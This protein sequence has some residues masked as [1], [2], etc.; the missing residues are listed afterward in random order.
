MTADTKQAPP[1]SLATKV[2][3]ASGGIVGN[4][5][6]R[7]LGS[8][9]LIFYNQVVGLPAALVASALLITTILDAFIDPALGQ[10]SDHFKSR[11]GRRHPFMYASAIPLVVAYVLVW[12]PPQGM[13]ETMT[14]AY[15]LVLMIVVRI[16]ESLFELPSAA[17]LPELT[18][19]YDERTGIVSIRLF[20]GLAA[21]MLMQVLA[22]KVFLK[23]NIHGGG[24]ILARH[25]YFGYGLASATIIGAAILISSL[26]T[27]KRIPY[28]SK[29]PRVTPSV[30]EMLREV[31]ST[32]NNG[33]YLALLA[34]GMLMF[35]AT[36]TKTALDMYFQLYFW[37]LTQSK[38]AILVG[39]TLIGTIAGVILAPLA[40]R[41]FGKRRTAVFVILGGIVGN[42]GPVL[43]RLVGIM[44]ANG[45]DLMF[46]ILFADAIA[47]F[48][49]AS[50]T[51]ICM[52]A[53]LNDV[54]EDV[55]VRTGRRSEGLLMA[56]DGFFRKLVS[57][58]GMFAAGVIL[59]MIAFPRHAARGSVSP[60]V[61][62]KLAYAYIPITLLLLTAIGLL[63]FYRITR[64]TH[65]ENLRILEARRDGRPQQVVGSDLSPAEAL[66][67]GAKAGGQ[68]D[69]TAA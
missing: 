55:E 63:Y 68:P 15:L 21:G 10:F 23:E 6:H 30:R 26:G 38:L 45:T 7:G 53:M 1:L 5:A 58:M 37:E 61:V 40:T 20:L 13:S 17:L 54:V 29:P 69:L 36:G 9:L 65:D 42:V 49:L 60:H 22:L 43:A 3:Y 34:L 50:I 2:S 64:E 8:F 47:T 18:K 48:C 52:T 27:H 51:S 12:S 33:S 28:L 62:D 46:G 66:S 44:P 11:W 16:S 35:T 19:N 41:R 57:G 4:V 56:A 14:F 24:G 32:L 67:S 25:G 39:A 59:T 31:A